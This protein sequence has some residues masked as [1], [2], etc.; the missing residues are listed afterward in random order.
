MCLILTEKVKHK[1]VIALIVSED[2]FDML[3][4]YLCCRFN[5]ALKFYLTVDLGPEDW[6]CPSQLCVGVD[7]H[8]QLQFFMVKFT[9]HQDLLGFNHIGSVAIVVN[10][11]GIISCAAHKPPPS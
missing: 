10:T 8:T 2:R 3:D 7:C 5:T 4:K 6:H 9:F 1:E 11:P